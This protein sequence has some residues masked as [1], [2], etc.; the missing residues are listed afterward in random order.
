MDLWYNK[1]EEEIEKNKYIIM[2]DLEKEEL[3]ELSKEDKVVC[4]Y[5]EELERLNSNPKFREYMSAEED[6]RK[7]YNSEIREATEKGEKKKQIDIAKNL[8]KMNL[9]LEQIIEA[10]GLTDEEVENIR[11]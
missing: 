5:M 8:M 1:K 3:K 6:A 10:T 4:K 2:L 11:S 7:I 9:T